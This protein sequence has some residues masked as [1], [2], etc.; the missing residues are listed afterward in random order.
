MQEIPAFYFYLTCMIIGG[1][2]G[3]IRGIAE[4]LSFHHQVKKL[5]YKVDDI[6]KLVKEQS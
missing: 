6:C 1:V 5:R 4:D 3:L 2:F